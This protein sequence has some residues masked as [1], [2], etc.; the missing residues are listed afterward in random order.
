MVPSS[1]AGSP[2]RCWVVDPND[3]T[4]PFLEGHRGAAVS[5]GLLDAGVPVL[6]VVYAYA[7]TDDD[8]DLVAWAEGCGA[9]T[10]NGVELPTNLAEHVFEAGEDPVH[11]QNA[12]VSLAGLFDPGAAG[13][14]VTAAVETS[15]GVW[16]S[17]SFAWV[18]KYFTLCQNANSTRPAC[19]KGQVNTCFSHS[20][21]A[22]RSNNG[23][24]DAR[25]A[26]AYALTTTS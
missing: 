10:R 3:G 23:K 6:G 12:T 21:A 19:K 16:S 24:D 14:S 13:F 26:S 18:A 25:A 22:R 1:P 7:H 9:P 2:R 17:A 8:G 5:I 20:A 15:L 11:S 4:S